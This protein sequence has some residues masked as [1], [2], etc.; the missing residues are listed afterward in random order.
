[1]VSYGGDG[2]GLYV[3]LTLDHQGFERHGSTYTR[4]VYSMVNTAAL[5]GLRLAES[6]DAESWIQRADYKDYKLY[7]ILTVRVAAPLASA[8]FKGQLCVCVCVCVH[9]CMHAGLCMHV[10]LHPQSRDYRG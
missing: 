9:A 5:Q 10:Y 1:M 8:L 2:Y 4:I 3:P 6:T 7:K